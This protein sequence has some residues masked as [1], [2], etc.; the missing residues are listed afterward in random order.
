MTNC[1][2]RTGV[3]RGSESSFLEPAAPGQARLA[4]RYTPG[5]EAASPVWIFLHGLGSDRNAAKARRF[6]AWLSERGPGFLALDFTGHGAS[7]GDC[8]GLSLSRNLEDIGR[9]VS[10]LD[11]Q[12][13]D[14]SRILVGSSMGGIAALWFAARWPDAVSRVFAIAPAFLMAA[15]LAASLSG[16]ERDG[17]A[18]R[19]FLSLPLGESPLEFGWGAVPDEENYPMERLAAELDTPA[20]LVHGTEDAVVPV[21]LSRGF[22]RECAAARLVEIEGG[23]H[24]LSE[25][26]HVDLAFETFWNASTGS[27]APQTA[28]FSP[29]SPDTS[30]R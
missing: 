4:F 7:G 17:W 11:R 21:A 6:G 13:P 30:P 23:D 27:A 9:A 14:A 8:R 24:R 25:R 1:R 10:F 18:Q 16:P 29:G 15:R 19:G 28:A 12:A 2:T 20:V 3:S 22:A 26:D 5:A